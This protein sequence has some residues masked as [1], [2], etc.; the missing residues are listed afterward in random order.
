MRRGSSLIELLVA[1][2]LMAL[3]GSLAVL[4]LLFV[5]RSARTQGRTLQVS[6]ELRHAVLVLSHDIDRL[7]P[8]DLVSVSDTL[9][10]FDAVLA[11]A[12]VCDR[13]S[14][15]QL[16]LGDVSALV[17]SPLSA[18]RAGDALT[19]WQ[20]SATRYGGTA[21]D[22]PAPAHATVGDWSGLGQGPCGAAGDALRVPRWRMAVDS[23]WAAGIA[24]GTPVLLQR[25]TRYTHYRSDGHWWIG[26][27]T[28][29]ASGWETVQ[30]LA[31]PLHSATAKGM[32]V[33]VF[34]LQGAPTSQP[35]E[36]ALLQ[37]TLRA[38]QTT[39]GRIVGPGDSVQVQLAL[40]GAPQPVATLPQP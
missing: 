9:L 20:V 35:A 26:R 5:A 33:Q 32:T 23:T 38:P 7:R 18:V 37:V 27:R 29:D 8:G 15:D 1:L 16:V 19:A 11:A 36:A 10:E 22:L 40:R 25:R 30:P 28:L 31:G 39:G 34:D 14:A 3:L 13:P 12:V 21:G 17:P 2:P 24:P 4:L 6:R